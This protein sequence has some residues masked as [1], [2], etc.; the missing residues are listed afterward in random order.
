MPSTEIMSNQEI[1]AELK[2]GS[3]LNQARRILSTTMAEIDT[4]LKQR[5]P[6]TI[7]EVQNLEF[8]AVIEIAALLGVELKTGQKSLTETAN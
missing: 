6:L 2:S 5:K 1:L 7:F 8:S 3:L 4:G